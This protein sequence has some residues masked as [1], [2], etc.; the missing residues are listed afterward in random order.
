M[1][2]SLYDWTRPALELIAPPVCAG[3]GL[4]GTIWC[5][6]CLEQTAILSGDL[7]PICGG[8]LSAA[9]CRQ[10]DAFEAVFLQ[11]SSFAEY[12]TPFRNLVI[13]LKY[14]PDRALGDVAAGIAVGAVAA[15]AGA[16][17]LAVPVP[18]SPKRFQR[19]GYNQ[20][21]LF[22]RPLAARLGI[23]YRTDAL[24]RVKETR[25]Q[26]GLTPDQRTENLRAAFTADRGAVSGLNLLLLDDVFTSGATGN[27]CAR[28]LYEAGAESVRVFTLARAIPGKDD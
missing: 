28:A 24:Q 4:T 15:F 25:S 7:C 18:L 10:C 11:A 22:G 2:A 12:R 6:A 5:R 26:V 3:C 20:V 27:M 13:R 19:R 1:R 16:V 21:D 14:T 8:Q 23:E 17:E 9:G